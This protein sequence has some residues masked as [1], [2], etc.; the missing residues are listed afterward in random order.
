M[1]PAKFFT[2]I[3]NMTL[4][5]PGLK[6]DFSGVQKKRPAQGCARFGARFAQAP[7][8]ST[9]VHGPP[10]KGWKLRNFGR[11]RKDPQVGPPPRFAK[12]RNFGRHPK[13]PQA[14]P[15]PGPSNTI[16]F[17]EKRCQFFD[18]F[19]GIFQG[20]FKRILKKFPGKMLKNFGEFFGEFF[21]QF[22]GGPRGLPPEN[23]P[24]N[25]PK[26]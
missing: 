8:T 1:L 18:E 22:P 2:L 20:G 7:W 6:A 9:M 10:P 26:N 11:H 5:R 23:S 15:P 12:L 3:P 17:Q 14:G 16:G 4:P 19:W 21:G 24:T 25:S 13:D